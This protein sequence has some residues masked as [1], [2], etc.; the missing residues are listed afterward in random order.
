[1]KKEMTKTEV[2]KSECYI[3]LVSAMLN[4]P[5]VVDE[6]KLSAHTSAM[7]HRLHVVAMEFL[8]M[9]GFTELE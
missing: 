1:M 4:N 6:E 2:F 9:M 3:M 7:T 8:S 5:N